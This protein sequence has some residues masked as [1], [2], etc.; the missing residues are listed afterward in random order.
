MEAG[1][2]TDC[3]NAVFRWR[4]GNGCFHVTNFSQFCGKF[5]RMPRN[6]WFIVVEIFECCKTGQL[7]LFFFFVFLPLPAQHG[8]SAPVQR[9]QKLLNGVAASSNLSLLSLLNSAK[10]ILIDPPHTHTPPTSNLVPFSC[11]SAVRDCFIDQILTLSIKRG[12]VN[13]LG[14]LPCGKAFLRSALKLISG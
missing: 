10:S 3:L 9:A 5:N 11:V 2:F 4:L 14:W 13:V 6:G 12:C 1:V 8:L 7:I